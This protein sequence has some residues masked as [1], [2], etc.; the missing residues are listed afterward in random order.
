MPRSFWF[1]LSLYTFSILFTGVEAFCGCVTTEG[2]SGNRKCRQTMIGMI[3][4]FRRVTDSRKWPGRQT[5]TSCGLGYRRSKALTQGQKLSQ[6]RT[7]R[8][9][10]E[11]KKKLLPFLY[12][13]PETPIQD[14]HNYVWKQLCLRALRK[15]SKRLNPSLFKGN[16]QFNSQQSESLWVHLALSDRT[17]HTDVCFYSSVCLNVYLFI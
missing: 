10:L 2:A 6:R 14:V 1:H 8:V 12:N 16:T 15:L 13:M 4:W 9:W 7:E 3:Y 5:G 11:K 17:S